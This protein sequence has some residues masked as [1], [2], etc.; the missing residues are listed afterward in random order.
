MSA[1]FKYSEPITHAFLLID[2]LYL[3]KG[4]TQMTTT[5]I[6]RASMPHPGRHVVRA[7][8]HSTDGL[9]E[10]VDRINTELRAASYCDHKTKTSISIRVERSL[11]EV[12]DRLLGM[13]QCRA[14]LHAEERSG[15]LADLPF[16]QLT[17]DTKR[18]LDLSQ[19]LQR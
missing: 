13:A 8:S 12:I 18:L 2:R 11:L 15:S 17:A 3:S 7:M 1:R 19:E 10:I 4:K 5:L 16:R 6:E 9:R 14:K